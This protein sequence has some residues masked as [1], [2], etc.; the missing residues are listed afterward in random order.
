MFTTC[1]ERDRFHKFPREMRCFAWKIQKWKQP[2]T[3][4]IYV[5]IQRI[6]ND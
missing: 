1:F 2:N 5:F 3:K 4:Q 6:N